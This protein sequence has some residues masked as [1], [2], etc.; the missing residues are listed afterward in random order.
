MSD[1]LTPRSALVLAVLSVLLVGLV[2]WFAFVSPQ[3]GKAASLEQ[4]IEAV[5]TRLDLAQRL[6]RSD[7]PDERVANLRR[8]AVA[9]PDDVAMPQIL[10]QLSAAGRSA[11]VRIDT[12]T[13]APPAAF[14]S[15]K[16]VPITLA[17]EGH[18][19]GIA[20][21]LE[22]LRDYTQVDGEEVRVSGR[23]YSVDS[24]A[25]SGNAG[26]S[27]DEGRIGATIT[28][29]AFSFEGAP[30]AAATPTGTDDTTGSAAGTGG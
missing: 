27:G 8:L 29:N 20:N 17:V 19:F 7:R 25:F 5:Q 11:R 13:P 28:L 9:M 16:A 23:L 15:Y 18:Y 4:E 26:G 3:R 24:I 1:R 2:G 12:V 14:G 22:L 6:K 10:R 21:F 30:A